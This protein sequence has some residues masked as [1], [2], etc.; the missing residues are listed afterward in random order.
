MP[1]YLADTWATNAERWT[2]S[3]YI[4]HLIFMFLSIVSPPR[5]ITLLFRS[6]MFGMNLIHY[7]LK[8]HPPKPYLINFSKIYFL[9]NWR[10]TM[11][12][13][14][15]FLCPH[16]HLE[17]FQLHDFPGEVVVLLLSAYPLVSLSSWF[18]RALPLLVLVPFSDFH[19]PTI[20]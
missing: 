4:M 1:S 12:V 2:C 17:I 3:M 5:R 18:M 6:H 13:C 19:C 10:K 16:C 11:Y 8:L 7:K 14:E 15:R 9:V 20:P